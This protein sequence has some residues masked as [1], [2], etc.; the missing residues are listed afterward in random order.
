MISVAGTK[1]TI[2]RGDDG[3]IRY[4]I[5]D[6]SSVVTDISGAA[7]AFTVRHR[8]VDHSPAFSLVSSPG[9]VPVSPSGGL[10]DVNIP[11]SV[12]SVLSPG[13]YRYDLQMTL[14]GKI[15]TLTK[16]TFALTEDITY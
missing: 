2:D 15:Y 16:G 3:A 12:T 1:I 14:V 13:N 10:L 7:F 8:T 9:I 6:L 4:T 5:T 11:G